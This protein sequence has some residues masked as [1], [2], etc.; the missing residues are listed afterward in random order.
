MG[1]LSVKEAAERLNISEATIYA[2]CQ[3]RRLPHVRIGVG[4]GAIRIED[5]A[6]VEFV[7]RARVPEGDLDLDP[8]GARMQG[9]PF[10][11]LDGARLRH[12]WHQQDVEAP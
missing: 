7:E 10:R 11:H 3:Q 5:Q 8:P 1:M 2:L 6:L 4:R 12:A 9:K